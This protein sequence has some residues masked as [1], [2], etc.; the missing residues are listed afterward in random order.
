MSLLLWTCLATYQ[1]PTADISNNK[2]ETKE[3][4]HSMK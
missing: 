1:E 3:V 2:Y 4:R